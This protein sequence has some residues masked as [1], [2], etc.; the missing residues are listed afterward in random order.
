[1]P[2]IALNIFFIMGQGIA[3]P[4]VGYYYPFYIVSGILTTTG[5]ALMYTVDEGTS[6]SAIYGH[7][8]LIAVGAAAYSIVPA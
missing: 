1:M 8:V 2:F 3:M 5:G 4:F 6:T 7:S